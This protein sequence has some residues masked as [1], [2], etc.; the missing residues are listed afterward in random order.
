MKK[1]ILSIFAASALLFSSCDGM[2]DVQPQGGSVTDEMLQDLVKKD[3]DK[4]LAPMLLG[5]IDYLHT[6]YY[7]SDVNGRGI[8]NW[9]LGMDF[10]GNDMLITDVTNYWKTEYTFNNLR[11]QV[12]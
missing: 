11:E 9:N 10:Q 8:L 4:V 12:S 5:M 7:Y 2:L 1:Y 6:G 3:A